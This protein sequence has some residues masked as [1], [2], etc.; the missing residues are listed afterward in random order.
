MLSLRACVFAKALEYQ[1]SFHTA[2]FALHILK[3]YELELLRK[4][5]V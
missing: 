1:L 5:G 4:I 2:S 3:L